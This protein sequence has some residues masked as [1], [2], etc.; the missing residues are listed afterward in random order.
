MVSPIEAMLGVISFAAILKA[1]LGPFRELVG[2]LI[3]TIADFL[4]E[5]TAVRR[6]RQRM[7]REAFIELLK[8]D[9]T[10]LKVDL[11]TKDEKSI[12][13]FLAQLEG[14]NEG[15]RRP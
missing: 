2:E 15:D 7:K 11:K 4:L 14:A 10:R 9:G 3:G 13:N 12:R 5:I 1:L 8:E 6:K